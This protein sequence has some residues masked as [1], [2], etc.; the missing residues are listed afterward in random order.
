M[1]NKGRGC[2]ETARANGEYPALMVTTTATSFQP[3]PHVGTRPTPHVGTQPTPHVGT[4]PITQGAEK[5]HYQRTGGDHVHQQQD[6]SNSGWCQLTP[7][8]CDV[9]DSYLIEQTY[10]KP[11]SYFNSIVKAATAFS[12]SVSLAP[13]C[14][15]VKN[16]FV[17]QTH[18]QAAF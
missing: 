18:W 1:Q 11:K 17:I 3:T 12:D 14:T 8:D 15:V 13:E 5:Q 4:Q 6:G 7:R 2:Q 16:T 10:S 9:P